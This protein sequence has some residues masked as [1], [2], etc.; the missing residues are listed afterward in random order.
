MVALKK[1][2]RL[3]GSAL[4]RAQP[5]DQRR[6]VVVSIGDATL[7][8]TDMQDRPLTHW[9]IA[10]IKRANPGTRPAVFHPEGDP[11][12]TLELA[13]DEAHM[14]D[15]LETLR[16]AVDRARPR[17]GR[18]RWVG[19]T[20]SVGVVALLAAFWLPGAL[21]NHTVSVVPSVKRADIGAALIDRIERM[22]GPACAEPAGLRA[23]QKL[24]ARLGS[25]PIAILPGTANTS[26]HLPGGY[27]LLD[28]AVVEDFEEPDVAA[29]FVLAE[30]V[31]AAAA[32]PLRDL[33]R[34]VGTRASFQLLTTGSLDGETLDAYAR[35]LLTQPRGVP[36]DE[37]LL[38]AFA[39][40]E[41]RSTPYAYANDVTGETVLSLI[42]ADPMA[43]RDPR[44]LLS[45]ADWLRLQNI[46]GG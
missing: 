43:G 40:R 31:L 29:G 41:V 27:I 3:E 38:A 20:A 32:D 44:A 46:C 4:W 14:I 15:A 6:D 13:A 10:A 17:P 28:R 22:T 1:Y 37:K 34:S 35:L 19:F 8:I 39:A 18:V 33:L 42:E 30:G 5:Q 21:V 9:S 11:G 7:T 23:I 12:E 25:G 36:E 2:A 16:R 24:R 45:D 26:M